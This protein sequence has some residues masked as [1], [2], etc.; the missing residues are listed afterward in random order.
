LSKKFNKISPKDISE[1]KFNQLIEALPSSDLVGTVNQPIES[2]QSSNTMETTPAVVAETKPQDNSVSLNR[3][4]KEVTEDTLSENF[5]NLVEVFVYEVG[6][7]SFGIPVSFVTEITNDYA[8]VSKLDGFIRSCLGTCEY[9]GKLIPIFDSERAYLK[10]S[11]NGKTKKKHKKNLLNNPIITV[12]YEGVMFALTMETHVGLVK[13]ALTQRGLQASQASDEF[14]DEIVWY[15]EKNLYIFSPEKISEVVTRELKGQLVANSE[16]H[17]ES[18]SMSGELKDSKT[19][20]YLIAKIRESF[21]AIEITKVLE[22]IE[23]FEVTSLY[24][25]SDFIRGLINLRGQVLACIDLSKDLGFDLMVID[26]RNKFIVI[27]ESGSDFAL[28]VDELIGIKAL[29][30]HIFQET[31]KVFPDQV[32]K[33]FPSFIDESGELKLIMRPELFIHSENLL[34]YRKN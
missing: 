7:L 5:D 22:V 4:R 12:D 1:E 24:K 34:D 26:E 29:D 14:L 15:N 20:D 17:L 3:T 9:R 16:L 10:V 18:R 32:A 28:C 25:V 21:V 23:G 19:I 31:E 13:V 8:P 30:G 11:K 27:S 33:F 2:E 6:N